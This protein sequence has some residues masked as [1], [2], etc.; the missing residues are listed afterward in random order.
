MTPLY[1][2]INDRLLHKGFGVL[3]EIRY[4]VKGSPQEKTGELYNTGNAVA[5][6]LYHKARRKVLLIRQFRLPVAL[7]G[8]AGGGYITE[9]CAGKIEDLSPEQTAIKEVREETGYRIAAPQR[10]MEL[11]MSPG[12]F[13]EQIYFYTAA[14]DEAQKLSEGGGLKREGESVSPQEMDFEE[15]LRMVRDGE[16]V[17]AKTV[18]LLQYA[19][20]QGLM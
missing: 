19:A 10:V 15:A 8:G 17:D 16:I 1:H 20:M 6:L 7:S 2:I 18:L 3:R 14:Y 11:Y 4:H 12:A 9:V 5:V 13:M